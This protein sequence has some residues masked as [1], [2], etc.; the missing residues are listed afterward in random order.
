MKMRIVVFRGSK[1]TTENPE[2][3]MESIHC[4]HIIVTSSKELTA[5]FTDDNTEGLKV[6]LDEGDWYG[7][8]LIEEG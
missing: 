5:Y 7:V 4:C 2:I 8:R 3:P 6:H 1:Q